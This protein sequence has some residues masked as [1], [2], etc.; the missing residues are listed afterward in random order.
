MLEAIR[1]IEEELEEEKLEEEEINIIVAID[2]LEAITKL[3]EELEEEKLEEDEIS[4]IVAIEILEAI[5]KLFER[6]SEDEINNVN[7]SAKMFARKKEVN[8]EAYCVRH[9]CQWPGPSHF[10]SQAQIQAKISMYQFYKN[11]PESSWIG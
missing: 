7:D 6:I 8:P 1:K 9:H 5:K 4:I 3:E 10:D 2:M 11:I